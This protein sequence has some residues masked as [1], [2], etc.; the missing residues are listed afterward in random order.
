[1]YN[2]EL[3]NWFLSA[4][5]YLK[6]C[7]E[8]ASI[9]LN[10]GIKNVPV[11][12]YTGNRVTINS[13]LLHHLADAGYYARLSREKNQSLLEVWIPGLIIFKVI[14]WSILRH[15][16]TTIPQHMH[17]QVD[18]LVGGHIA[19]GSRVAVT[20]FVGEQEYEIWIRNVDRKV[21]SDTYQLMYSSNRDLIKVINDFFSELTDVVTPHNPAQGHYYFEVIT[22]E[23]SNSVEFNLHKGQFSFVSGL[24]FEQYIKGLIR[25]S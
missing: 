2:L 9:L 5:N 11:G 18:K 4:N 12:I 17:F 14:D 23:E 10:R 20:A 21:D 7:E 8:N 13:P 24:Q 16:G 1:M 3:V 19:R 15:G 22:S 6:I 25:A